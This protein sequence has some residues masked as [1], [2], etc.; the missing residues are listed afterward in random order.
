[1]SPVRPLRCLAIT[2]VLPA[3]LFS[4]STGEAGLVNGTTALV[5]PPAVAAPVEGPLDEEEDQRAPLVMTALNRRGDRLEVQPYDREGHLIPTA[6]EAISRFLRCQHTGRVKRIHP[7]TVALLYQI[8]RDYPGHELVVLSGFRAQDRTSPHRRARAVDLRVSGVSSA[9]LSRQLWA[10][11][12]G[13]AVGYYPAR[14]FVHVDV[15]DVPVRW[16]QRGGINHYEAHARAA[17]QALKPVPSHFPLR[18]TAER[19]LA[20]AGEPR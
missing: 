4:S 8:S 13:I 6:H 10:T 20:A 16:V 12:D 17:R 19:L 3:M 18:P 15:R 2:S 11:Y 9:R 5:P 7:G 14:G 1:M